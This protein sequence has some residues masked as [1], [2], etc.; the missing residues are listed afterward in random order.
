MSRKT[1][2]TW[3]LA[4]GL[5][6]RPAA[7]VAGMDDPGR[8]AAF[9]SFSEALGVVDRDR[10]SKEELAELAKAYTELGFTEDE[11]QAAPRLTQERMDSVDKGLP[12]LQALNRELDRAL[13]SGDMLMHLTPPGGAFSLSAWGA[14]RAFREPWLSSRKRFPP[15]PPVWT[16]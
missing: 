13:E 8:Q 1:G 16:T 2:L 9:E 7:A 10:L 5:L 11:L 14:T 3:A 15:M 4:A 6:W 12:A